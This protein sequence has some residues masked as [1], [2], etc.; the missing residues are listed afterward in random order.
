VRLLP[1]T[2]DGNTY[3]VEFDGR[4]S[5]ARAHTVDVLRLGQARADWLEVT[6]AALRFIRSKEL[7]V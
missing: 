6:R 4:V 5:H 7:A 2:G 1:K 3:R